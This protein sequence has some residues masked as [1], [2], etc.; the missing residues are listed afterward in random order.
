MQ[1]ASQYAFAIALAIYIGRIE[2]IDASLKSVADE[3][4]GLELTRSKN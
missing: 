1:K 2:E 3:P 4:G